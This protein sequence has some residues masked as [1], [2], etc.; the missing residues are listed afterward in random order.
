MTTRSCV[1]PQ[2]R[3]SSSCPL[4]D[5]VADI[6]TTAG[7]PRFPAQHSFL[8]G[9]SDFT[10]NGAS[11]FDRPSASPS[12]NPGRHMVRW[13]RPMCTSS[14]PRYSPAPSAGGYL[15]GIMLF[16]RQFVEIVI[17]PNKHDDPLFHR[18]SR[19]GLIDS[20]TPFSLHRPTPDAT[21]HS[22]CCPSG[23]FQPATHMRPSPCL[24]PRDSSTSAP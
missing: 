22:P 15:T 17:P 12:R 3:M 19:E 5:L 6:P 18:A 4:V 16:L 21:R 7:Y 13:N 24:I 10:Q 8:S 1:A 14:I 11:L 9:I 23:L 20:A 2:L